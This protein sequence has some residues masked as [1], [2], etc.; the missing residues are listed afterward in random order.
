MSYKA[1]D[2]ESVLTYVRSVKGLRPFCGPDMDLSSKE[3]GDGNLNQVFVITN[4]SSNDKIVVKQALP[5]LRVAGDSWPLTRER[6]RFETAALLFYG[7]VVE[8]L[9]PI[10]FHHDKAMS[11]IVMEFLDNF[12]VMRKCVIRGEHFEHFPEH[13]GRFMAR[14]HFYTS[15]AYLSG[16]EKK[17]R[18]KTFLNPQLCKLQED[19]VFTNPFMTS[20]ENSC[21]PLLESDVAALRHDADLKIAVAEAKAEYMTRAQSLLHGDLHTGSIMVNHGRFKVIDPEFAFFGPQGYD[22]GTLFANLVLG[23]L[24]HTYHTDDPEQRESYQ[25]HL[26][27][28]IP[29][30]WKVYSQ[31]FDELW[32]KHN[33]GDLVPGEYWVFDSGE[34]AFAAFRKAYLER[35]LKD[36]ARLGGCEILR[37]LMGIVSVAELTQ[38]DD[39]HTRAV[40]ER[41]A[42]QVARTWLTGAVIDAAALAGAA[43]LVLGLDER[44]AA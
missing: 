2:E 40:A 35:I 19:F 37:R 42:I 36:T 39:E 30:I 43:K 23:A 41:Q 25:H 4:R 10:V 20:P 17:A 22:V 32:R 31:T 38:I 29:S 28:L 14:T 18:L 11:L 8:D 9:A 33:Q 13:L 12:E 5:Y 21:N 44:E 15:D 1:L 34:E 16:A 24:S 27:D 7:D 26:L 6:M 3:I